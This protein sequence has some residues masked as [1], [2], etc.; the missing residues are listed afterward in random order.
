MLRQPQAA[1]QPC[2]GL[3]VR[4]QR[5]VGEQYSLSL[6]NT[7]DGSRGI[8]EAQPTFVATAKL[9][10]SDGSP[11]ESSKYRLNLACAGR[12]FLPPIAI[13]GIAAGRQVTVS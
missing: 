3:P 11:R 13:G 6:R 5:S 4:A 1:C 12:T 7:A 2:R 9:N 10:T 8:V